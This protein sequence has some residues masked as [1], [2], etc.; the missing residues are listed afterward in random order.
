MSASQLLST[1][2]LHTL[3]P[4]RCPAC[5]AAGSVPCVSCA[6]LIERCDPPRVAGVEVVVAGFLYSGVGADLVRSL[7]S[8][9]Q[10]LLFDWLGSV[11]SASVRRASA[12][13]LLPGPVGW[14]TWVP[15]SAQGRRSRGFD[16]SQ[17]IAQRVA[18]NLGVSSGQLLVRRRGPRQ[19]GTNR[20]QR[21]RGPTLV[22]HPRGRARWQQDSARWREEPRQRSDGGRGLPRPMVQKPP[23]VLIVDDVLTTGASLRTAART[24]RDDLGCSIVGAVV[25]HNP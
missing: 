19:T 23:V 25:A 8:R 1:A 5:G 2:F 11:V 4:P 7:K 10:P 22:A 12:A 13:H 16:Q 20:A 14:V 6:S 24:V 3:F 9:N 15:S 21:L 17:Q 18:G